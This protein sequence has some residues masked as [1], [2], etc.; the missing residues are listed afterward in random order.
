MADILCCTY[1]VYICFISVCFI[2]MT[3]KI[4]GFAMKKMDLILVYQNSTYT[5]IKSF[6]LNY[7]GVRTLISC[8]LCENVIP[9]FFLIRF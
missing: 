7:K 3:K 9:N 1:T 4:L 6:V 2:R 5:F 8:L